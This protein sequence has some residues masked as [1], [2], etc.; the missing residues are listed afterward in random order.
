M[1]QHKGFIEQNMLDNEETDKLLDLIKSV[2]N[3]NHKTPYYLNQINNI[4][5]LS[6]LRTGYKNDRASQGLY[7][8]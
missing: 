4:N 3:E 5:P 2:N 6:N 8:S 7:N 1:P